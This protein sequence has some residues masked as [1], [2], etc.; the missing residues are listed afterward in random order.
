MYDGFTVVNCE[1]V[2]AVFGSFDMGRMFVRNITKITTRTINAIAPITTMFRDRPCAFLFSMIIT[3]VSF[4]YLF[5][6]F[7]FF[8]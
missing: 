7:V 2:E 3:C 1:H 5:I 8:V 6:S 4:F